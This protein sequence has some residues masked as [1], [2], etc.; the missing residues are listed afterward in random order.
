MEGNAFRNS[1]TGDESWFTLEY[2]HSEKWKWK[3]SRDVMPESVKQQIG[4]KEF[5]LTVICGVDG[6]HV[7]DLMTSQCC[8][9]AEYFVSTV[10]ASMIAK[11][12]PY[13]RSPH[14]RRLPLHPDNCRVPLSTVTEQFITEDDNCMCHT[15]SVPILHHQT[16]GFSLI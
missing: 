7:V 12:F 9:R 10:M 15:Y 11:V 16:S 1:L 3:V 13:G 8:F 2:Q 14:A 6:S 4:T 5:V